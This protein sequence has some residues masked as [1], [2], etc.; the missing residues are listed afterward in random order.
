MPKRRTLENSQ[1]VLIIYRKDLG[2]IEQYATFIEYRS[3]QI[4]N[5]NHS[6]PVFSCEN[7]E[8]TGMDCFWILPE[9]INLLSL[10]RLQYDIIRLQLALLEKNMPVK[11]ND[12]AFKDPQKLGYDPRDETWLETDLAITDREKKW[13]R[14]ERE[15]SATFYQLLYDADWPN[16]IRLFNDQFKEDVTIDQAKALNMKR[17]RYIMGSSAVRLSGNPDHSVWK[18]VAREFEEVHRRID[19]RMRQWS[20]EHKN[21]FPLI[22]TKKEFPFNPGPYFNECL[23]RIPQYF[24]NT[25][26]KAIRSGSL[27]R[28]VGYDPKQKYIRVDF[29]QEIRQL[30]TP[31]INDP[32]WTSGG[33][34]Y[35]IHVNRKNIDDLEILSGSLDNLPKT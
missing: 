2:F 17:M 12:P 31:T 1:Q 27:L 14:F 15:N 13:F 19:E 18:K 35:L 20:E 25:D 28:I 9:E 34:D 11:I 8:F 4:G 6:I 32:P 26:L 7:E 23:E 22:K 24:T 5:V 29:P 3:I 21:N 33:A 10:Q 30:I 16:I